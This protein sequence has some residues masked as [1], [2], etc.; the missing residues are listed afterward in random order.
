MFVVHFVCPA[1]GA[2]VGII[3]SGKPF[4]AL[5]N[6]YFVYN[7]ISQSVQRNTKADGG[8]PIPLLLQTKHDAE[9]AGDC[10]YQKEGVV[11]F[12]KARLFLMMI[13][14]EIP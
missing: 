9:P 3:A 6:D 5:V 10:E 1:D 13:L 11:F 8:Y 2:Y 4:E 12:E 14:V 7:K